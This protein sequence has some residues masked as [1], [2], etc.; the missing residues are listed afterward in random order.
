[1][2]PALRRSSRETDKYSVRLLGKSFPV[3]RYSQASSGVEWL[4][5]CNQ[6]PHGEV[7]QGDLEL[8][9][10]WG[11]FGGDR[12]REYRAVWVLRG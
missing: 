8:A 2:Q 4:R 1:M 3:L 12:D 7:K 9:R 10:S 6:I 5:E 11:L